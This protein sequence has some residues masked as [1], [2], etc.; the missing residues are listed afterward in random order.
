MSQILITIYQI[1]VTALLI[2]I[3]IAFWSNTYIIVELEGITSKVDRIL[4]EH[5]R[6]NDYAAD[7]LNRIIKEEE[8]NLMNT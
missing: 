3:F 1:F 2:S 5:D 7:K 8:W 4:T 6:F